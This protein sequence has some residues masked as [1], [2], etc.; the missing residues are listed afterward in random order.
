MH[1]LISVVSMLFVQ[2]LPDTAELRQS[3]QC[4]LLKIKLI[5]NANFRRTCKS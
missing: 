2:T 3:I 1:L 4:V 5:R